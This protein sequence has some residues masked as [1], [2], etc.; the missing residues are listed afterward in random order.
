LS[1]TLI[2][3]IGFIGVVIIQSKKNQLSLM[4]GENHK[5]VLKLKNSSWFQIYWKAG[6]FLFILNAALFCLTISIFIIL[7]FLII[8]YIHLLVMVM[9]VIGS[10][11]FW[12]IVNMA[13]QGTNGNRLKLSIIGSSFYA[14]V[15]FLFIYWLITLKPTYEGED[16]FMSSIGLLFGIIVSMVAF[17]SCLIT[18]G[19]TF[20]RKVS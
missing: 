7:G 3:L 16:M 4:I 9:A 12:I 1:F 6:F 15:S 11:F 14:I 19:L 5:L 10:F 20:K 17:I 18:T 2:L 13:W 8:P